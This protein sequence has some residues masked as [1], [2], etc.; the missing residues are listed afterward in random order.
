M[1]NNRRALLISCILILIT[2][3]GCAG[4][5]RITNA[6][7]AK[8]YAGEKEKVKE[9][10]LIFVPGIFGTV[11]ED[12]DTGKVI[13]GRVAEGLIAQLSLPI[14]NEKISENKDNVVPMKTLMKFSFI[15][16]I[17][18][19]GIYENTRDIAVNAAGYKVN[20]TVFSLSYDWRRDLVEAA[21]RLGELIDNIKKD[22]K[23]P[24][25][26]V[27]IV[28]HSAG[29]LVSRY[30]A[31][32]GTVDVL[33][34]DPL[35]PPTYAGAKNINKIIMLGTPNRGSLESFK[36]INNGLSIPGIGHATKAI[37]FTMPSSFELMPFEGDT[38]FIDYQGN[39]LPVNLYDPANWEKY[40]WS[41][42]ADRGKYTDQEKDAQRKFLKNVLKRASAFQKALNQGDPR[43]E[44]KRV[45]YIVLGSDANDT[46]EKAVL[47]KTQS[48]WKTRFD[49]H[50]DTIHDKA[51]APGDNTVTRR[52]LLG[53]Y[54]S[55][56]QTQELPSAYE[57][58]FAQYHVDLAS[59]PTF[60]DNV[61]HS[62]LDR[63]YDRD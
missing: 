39:D 38:T 46:L 16:G 36:C 62:L 56:G 33:D 60:M 27:D 58:F 18:E 37:T 10:P 43:E 8:I 6:M 12:K 13:W 14:D 30:Y 2:C 7:V 63:T 32:Y 35:P 3:S 22:S 40:N 55:N 57:I 28:C 20:K 41:V 34:Q 29:G 48:G 61:L 19:K 26:K 50:D 17:L 31:K 4:G 47:Q 59:D 9:Y 42:F 21:Q 25:L 53:R 11:L 44:R 1:I 24:D 51:F 49:P 54:E 45:Y 5:S 15:P 52:S 23:D